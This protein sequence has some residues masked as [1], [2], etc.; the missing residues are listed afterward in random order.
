MELTEDPI[1]Q[2]FIISKDILNTM[3]FEDAVKTSMDMKELGLMRPPFKEFSI[4]YNGD[5]ESFVS[6]S[7]GN[8]IQ[9]WPNK[10]KSKLS[11]KF[12]YIFD[13]RL[14]LYDI[15]MRLGYE[16]S[17]AVYVGGEDLVDNARWQHNAKYKDYIDE[18]TYV[19]KYI[20]SV[21]AF[22]KNL[23]AVLCVL[24]VT[25]NIV[26]DVRLPL[27]IHG[28]SRKRRRLDSDKY[29]TT[30]KIGSIIET[31][32]SNDSIGTAVRPH[33]RRGHIRNQHFGEG[34]K[35]IKKIFIQ[36][37]FVNA[38]EGWIADQRKAYVVKAA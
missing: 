3:S 7:R 6:W 31:Y 4:V 2:C 9:S 30:L 25:K 33:L 17:T 26:K 21:Y 13:D 5:L 34:N 16:N 35:E 15:Y 11:P 32:R 19:E 10:Q 28:K 29:I 38:D 24:L 1:H 12:L 8:I 22:A 18:E 27:K 37:V 36:P 20:E 23:L 14:E